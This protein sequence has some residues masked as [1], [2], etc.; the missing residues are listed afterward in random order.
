MMLISCVYRWNDDG[1][2]ETVL[3]DCVFLYTRTS[4]EKFCLPRL[5]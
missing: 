4:R 3:E 2:M 1:I 5:E